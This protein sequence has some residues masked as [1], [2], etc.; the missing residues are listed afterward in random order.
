MNPSSINMKQDWRCEDYEHKMTWGWPT[1]MGV[2]TGGRI[3]V[4]SLEQG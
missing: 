2:N 3:R 4:T 1:R